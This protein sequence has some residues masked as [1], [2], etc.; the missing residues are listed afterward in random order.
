MNK[1]EK[2]T[3]AV[4][5]KIIDASVDISMTPPLEADAIGFGAKCIVSG[6]LPYNNPKPEQLQNGCWVRSNGEYSL[7][8]QG[9]MRGMPYGSYPRLF[10]IWL[11]SEA[12]K[13]GDRKIY[14]GRSIRDYLSRVGV[15]SSRGKRGGGTY[16]IE[17]TSRFLES[18][19]GFSRGGDTSA[20]GNMMQFADDYD[21]FWEPKQLNQDSLFESQITL[22]KKF[23]DEITTYNIPLDMRAI[24]V[25]KSSPIALDIYQWLAYRL[26]Y[27]K[28]NQP[29]RPT[30]QQLNLQFGSGYKR[31]DHF[32]KNFIKK[33][34]L[35]K[36]AYPAAKIEETK[37]GLI[38]F[39]SP[40][41]VPKKLFVVK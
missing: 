28:G 3:K 8:V 36:L 2:S 41:P 29:A 14:A 5:K 21:L 15:D 17:Q 10:T 18:R 30:W 38:L 33:L 4:V 37:T 25:L 40:P 19:V 35:V 16:L 7:W 20:K 34:K 12:I 26:H 22:T 31:I 6:C 11:T 13:T 1:N 9:G 32:K 27:I 24:A 23:F 39:N